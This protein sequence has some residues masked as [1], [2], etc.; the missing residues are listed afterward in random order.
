[1]LPSSIQIFSGTSGVESQVPPVPEKATTAGFKSFYLQME[2]EEPTPLPSLEFD[3]KSDVEDEGD[4]DVEG[5]GNIHNNSDSFSD[6]DDALELPEIP[7]GPLADDFFESVVSR[8]ELATPNKGYLTS[9][10]D[11]DLPAAVAQTP[12]ATK[13]SIQHSSPSGI[14]L[15][16]VAAHI[17]PIESEP[18]TPVLTSSEPRATATLIMAAPQ[19][20]ADVA[21]SERPRPVEPQSERG[22]AIAAGIPR[23]PHN[24]HVP[25][26]SAVSNENAAPGIQSPDQIAVSSAFG[27]QPSPQS[28]AG[29]PDRSVNR[30]EKTD[31]KANLILKPGHSLGQPSEETRAVSNRIPI[32]PNDPDDAVLGQKTTPRQ[33]PEGYQLRTSQADQINPVLQ[34]Q[35]PA[36]R[37]ILNENPVSAVKILSTAAAPISPIGIAPTVPL[38]PSGA[39]RLSV[40]QALSQRV[41]GALSSDDSISEADTIAS[42]AAIDTD[43]VDVSRSELSK[44]TLPSST[45]TESMRAET[46]RSAAVQM[47]QALGRQP[48][49]P[50]EI[51][52]NPEELGRVR[53]A[54]TPSDTGLAV[55]INAE[56][57]ETLDL[58][59][60]HIEQLAVEFRRLGYENV[61]FEFSGD[62]AGTSDQSES[63]NPVQSVQETESE[64]SDIAQISRGSS[65][66]VDLRM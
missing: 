58:M 30:A 13:P 16:Q 11:D 51:A 62:G 19:G 1:M 57:P 14:H 7:A 32:E 60:R 6:A 35:A 5:A 25:A 36:S 3:L 12:T 21:R 47:A 2:M 41:F 55:T 8:S 50:V 28:L 20:Q 45:P 24:D 59:R 44:L 52:L 49:K 29:H 40:E 63:D 48:D 61:G 9:A 38:S 10:K 37:Q 33:I 43:L 23:R 26:T 39:S 4:T 46:A 54:L 42:T 27:Q 34:Q 31:P 17:E 15:L 53:I 64:S 56:R 66:G 22:N 18:V 65:T